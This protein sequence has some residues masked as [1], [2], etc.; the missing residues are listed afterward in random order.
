MVDPEFLSVSPKKPST[1]LPRAD[2]LPSPV[3]NQARLPSLHHDIGKTLVQQGC[4]KSGVKAPIAQV[5]QSRRFALATPRIKQVS[6]KSNIHP[7]NCAKMRR[8]HQNV[9]RLFFDVRSVRR[10]CGFFHILLYWL[11]HRDPYNGLLYSPLMI[12]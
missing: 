11:F 5:L 10:G 2:R 12:G 7:Q 4:P 3:V 9:V 1:A 6:I 8:I